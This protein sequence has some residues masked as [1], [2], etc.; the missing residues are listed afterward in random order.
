[1][2]K[3]L[4]DETDGPL[5]ASELAD[6]AIAAALV[7]SLLA[8]G[9]LLAAG[10]FFQILGTVVFAVLAARHRTRTVVLS[11]TATALFTVLLGG[12]GPITQSIIAGL[13][14]WTGGVSLA[15]NRS[16]PRT[17]GLALLVGWP[18]VAL[19]T[20]A[21]FSV[22]TELRALAFENVENQWNGL[23]RV[24]EPLGFPGV[25]DA[26]ADFIS[27]QLDWWMI[28]VPVAQLFVSA[29]YALLVRR[30]GRRVLRGVNDALGPVVPL[31]LQE[32]ETGTSFEG[33]APLPLS[34]DDV[35][36]ERQGYVVNSGVTVSVSPADNVAI[37][38][39]NGAGK[40]TLLDVLAGLIPNSGVVRNGAP[41][42]GLTGGTSYVSQ[43]PEGQVLAPTVAEDIRWGAAADVDV[44]DALGSVGLVGFDDRLTS[45]L[46]GG[47]LQRLALAAALAR[48]PSLLLADEITSML[49]PEGREQIN[50][51]L[52]DINDR[53]VA[54]VRTSHLA[55]DLAEADRVVTIGRPQELV[56]NELL[57]TIYVG[58]PVLTLTDVSYTY[59]GGKPWA[60]T[61]LTDID[62]TI[63]SGELVLVTGSNG[64]GKS[65][66]ARVL[67]GLRKPTEGT[68]EKEP[69]TS[70]AI[71]FQHARLQLL[72][73][74]VD[75]ELRSLA[76]AHSMDEKG[77]AR[78]ERL[79]RAVGSLGLG[80]LLDARV[81]SLSGGQQRRVLL[82]GLL[83]RGASVIVLDEPLAGLD[84][85]GR[86]QL[87]EVVDDLR[88]QGTA[89]V[90]VSHDASWGHD[91]VTRVLRLDKGRLS[92]ERSDA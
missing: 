40:S 1:M 14:G 16:I 54:V 83:A 58:R 31:S 81:D 30:L 2:T 46:S 77:R 49:D 44:A 53:G 19:A 25:R 60:R 48:K 32:P 10:L 85:E 3:R 80:D 70:V 65:T 24:F 86:L 75:S 6:A 15:R 5:D 22:A 82:A 50:Q 66:F 8:I 88:R 7:F 4:V 18:P 72:R 23:S 9:R 45:E 69:G 36:I 89:V 20:V 52:T 63:R 17:V 79:P 90:V 57:N 61:V 84:D 35:A 76:G 68:V 71:A 74:L 67:A 33:G 41:R 92:T 73:P 26:G 21:F 39:R 55:G 13:F 91:R 28:A 34:L 27:G 38:G 12:T 11:V 37:A 56:E 59:D 42:L 62:L 29:A 64:S 78:L 51:L 47:E 87:A 43:R